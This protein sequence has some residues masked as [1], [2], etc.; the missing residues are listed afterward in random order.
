MFFFL[1][2]N[3]YSLCTYFFVNRP[4]QAHS[5]V[6]HNELA[7][8]LEVP[9]SDHER[10]ARLEAE[11]DFAEIS[12]ENV[13]AVRERFRYSLVSLRGKI[14]RQVLGEGEINLKFIFCR[15]M[16]GD[17]LVALVAITRSSPLLSFSI[18]MK[19]II[20]LVLPFHFF[21]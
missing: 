18:P 16:K 7:R 1:H 5:L 10:L 2:S 21:I 8:L 9:F 12:P 14:E 19:G 17:T 11:T 15:L 6:Y 13:G 20:F 3:F 4:T